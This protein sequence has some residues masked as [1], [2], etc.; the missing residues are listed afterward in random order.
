MLKIVAV[1]PYL[2]IIVMVIIGYR[3]QCLNN[4]IIL[5]LPVYYVREMSDI[6][7]GINSRIMAEQHNTFYLHLFNYHGR[8]NIP[9]CGVFHRFV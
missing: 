4:L 6:I 7:N 3:T 1:K 5:K 2:N 8:A 9:L